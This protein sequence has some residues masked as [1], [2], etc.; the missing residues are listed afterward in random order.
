M[1]TGHYVAKV[2]K[3]MTTETSA[4]TT[5][6]TDD[7]PLPTTSPLNQAEVILSTST[8]K[9]REGYAFQGYR[10]VTCKAR[11]GRLD[12]EEAEIAVDTGCT[13]S[14]ADRA[15]IEKHC[16]DAEVKTVPTTVRVRGIGKDKQAASQY[17][18]ITIY[19]PGNGGIARLQREVHII[20]ML[21]AGLLLGLDILKPEGIIVDP[22]REAMTIQSCNSLIVPIQVHSRDSEHV[23]R[24]VFPLLR[25]IVPA[26]TE[27]KVQVS[28]HKGKEFSLPEDRDFLFEPST[29]QR[30]SVYA[31]IVDANIN[32]VLVRNDTEEEMTL[33]RNAK[34]GTIIEYEADGC[35]LADTST[36]HLARGPKR[37]RSWLKRQGALGLCAMIAHS[38]TL[39]A[40][41]GSLT[42]PDIEKPTSSRNPMPFTASLSSS[43]ANHPEVQLE[44]GVTVY[45][46][47]EAVRQLTGLVEEFQDVWEDKGDLVDIPETEWMDIPLVENWQELY[48]AGQ[49][50]V[51]PVARPD[52]ELIDKEFDQMQ[53]QG[54]LSWIKEATLFTFPCFVVWRILANGSRKG[55]VVVDIRALNKITMPDA[56][57]VPIQT[58]ILSELREAA[59]I[60]VMDC[61]RFFHQWRVNPEHRNRLT[62]SSHRGQETSNVAVMGFRNSVAYV[63]RQ[64]DKILRP[65]RAFA[66]AYIDDIVDFTKSPMIRDYVSYLRPVLET[67]RKYKI[68]LSP[69]KTFLG[70][71]FIILL[72]Q[73]VD[74]FRLTIADEKLK[75]IQKLKFPSTLSQLEI[76]L[77]L[78]GWLRQFIPHYAAIV[79]PLQD[80]KTS[81]N[82]KLKESG[83]QAQGAKRKRFAGRLQLAIPSPQEVEAFRQL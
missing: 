50:R 80:R 70:Y 30:V 77:G 69:S 10:Y 37:I 67:L 54:K 66:R 15:F 20:D 22:S 81:L 56:Y 82:R 49:A 24:N 28:G 39:P 21:K 36:A 78:T 68:S 18:N 72:G 9:Y 38:A 14:I 19:L 29:K 47:T 62:I 33:G 32:F 1:E 63:Q 65:F 57:P 58:D 48:K 75:A 55:R 11:L 2:S 41:N 76:Y 17:V 31:H 43:T 61:S 40:Y 64:I 74:A 34:L 13:M 51:Y 12:G 71:L 35:Y 59:F 73:K 3:N 23:R 60:S 25:T 26:H 27:A 44:N 8:D 5:A 6:N 42:A 83:E 45:G 16:P 53:E 7:K 4:N 52:R 46:E 79:K